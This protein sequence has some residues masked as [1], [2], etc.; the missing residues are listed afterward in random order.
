MTIQSVTAYGYIIRDNK[1]LESIEN[2]IDEAD[3]LLDSLELI[4]V[5]DDDDAEKALIF[6]KD[7]KFYDHHKKDPYPKLNM[8]LCKNPTLKQIQQIDKITA[9][10]NLKQDFTWLCFLTK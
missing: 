9:K 6:I 1:E 5:Y 2:A 4:N 10:F 8:H 7:A 3:C